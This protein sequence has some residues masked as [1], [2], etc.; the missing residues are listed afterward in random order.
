MPKLT[1]NADREVIEQA[2]RL[3][4]ENGT[5]VSAMFSQFV[6]AM[7]G[8]SVSPRPPLGPITRRVAGI[9]PLP[10]DRPYRAMIEQAIVERHGR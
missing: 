1:L 7:S 8:R 4:S 6:R 2:K 3:A 9:A 5:S 10:A